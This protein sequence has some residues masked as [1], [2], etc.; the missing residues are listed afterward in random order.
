[1]AL[2]KCIECGKEISTKAYMCP[3]C[4]AMLKQENLFFRMVILA[5]IA[6]VITVLFFRFFEAIIFDWTYTITPPV[7]P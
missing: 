1:M 6:L 2:T 3:S 5:I 4:G 7:A